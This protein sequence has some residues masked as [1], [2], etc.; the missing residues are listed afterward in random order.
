[1]KVTTL[2]EEPQLLKFLVYSAPGSGKTSLIRTLLPVAKKRILVLSAEAGLLSI[3]GSDVDVID[4]SRNEAGQE[5]ARN[6]RFEFLESR[7]LPWLT[8]DEARERYDWIVLDSLT[9]VGQ[10]LQDEL[11]EKYDA[12]QSLPMWGEFGKRARSLVKGFRDC[13]YNVYVTALSQVE[14]DENGSRFI[15]VSLQGKVGDLIAAYFDEV[16]YLDL[17]KQPDGAERR[18]LVTSIHPRFVAKDR[19]GRLAPYEAPDLGAVVTKILAPPPAGHPRV[20]VANHAV[21][22]QPQ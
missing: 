1:M 13:A 18:T 5:I 22:T 20:S 12:K 7:V 11:S 14:K 8:K 4:I 9:E 6:R 16:F 10:L 2:G 17:I 15:N 21:V 3:R 19:S